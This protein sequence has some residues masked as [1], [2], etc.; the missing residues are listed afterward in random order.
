MPFLTPTSIAVIGA[1]HE[2]GKVGHE[3]FKN[4]MTQGYKGHVYPVNPKGG[5]LIDREVFVSV[6][7]LPTVDL[8]VIVTPAKTVPGILEEC[9]AKGIK[10]TVIISA[11]FGAGHTKEGDALEKEVRTIAKKHGMSLI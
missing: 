4:L 1:S 7:D 6:K 11:G 5:S 3:I 10:H 2:P 9:G 8:A